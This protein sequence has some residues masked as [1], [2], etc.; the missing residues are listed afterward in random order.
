M[1]T[2]TSKP[3]ETSEPL[4]NTDGLLPCAGH[5]ETPT[6]LRCSRCDRPICGRCAI[7]ATVGQHCPW[8]VAEARKSAPKIRSA[9]AATAP[10]VVA[11]V[12]LNAAFFLGQALL[13]GLTFR[14]GAVPGAIAD[15]QWYRL[16]TPML[17][18]GH[19]WHIVLN[20]LVLWIYGPSVEQA[21]GTA[22]FLA[23]YVVAGFIGGVASF[24]LG[25]CNSLGVGASGAIFGIVG[26]L[27]V[28]LY[29]RRR[30]T[31]VAGY[32]KNL[33]LFVGLNM[34]LGLVWPRVDLFAHL[35]GLA[36]GVALGA[37]FDA[38]EGRA[39][40][41]RGVLVAA[42]LVAAGVAIAASRATG[43]TC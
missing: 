38:G 4:L 43:F 25:P 15:G 28:H 8:C 35:G 21:F 2:V 39:S 33:L 30:S 41:G 26:V 42:G 31:F 29:N 23:M 9:M 1:E 10:G 34:V 14:L 7:P 22:R 20:M 40:T 17:L 27:L 11:I 13:P 24:A 32:L 16:L 19:V 5:P 36:A 6:R 12:A 18:H 37:G 3:S